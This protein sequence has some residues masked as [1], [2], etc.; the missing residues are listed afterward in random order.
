VYPSELVIRESCGCRYLSET[1][2][3]DDLY[4]RPPRD[5]RI[6]QT[7][8]TYSLS[9][10]FSE[11]ARILPSCGIRSCFIVRYCH[12]IGWTGAWTVPDESELLFAFSGGLRMEQAEHAR[13]PTASLLPETDFAFPEREIDLIKP[14]FFRD[15]Q[16]GYIILEANDD[17]SRNLEELRGQISDSLKFALMM[18]QQKETEAR[19]A[20][21]IEQLRESNRM[22]ED[23][24]KE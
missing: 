20:K 2:E 24:S 14:L 13:F 5:F 8:Q 21:I 1:S 7:M 16:Y 17:D 11:I 4:V 15:E 23:G 10:L 9:D 22:L 18:N 12:P 19:L 3:L 6:H